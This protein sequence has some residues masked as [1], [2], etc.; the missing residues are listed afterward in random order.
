MFASKTKTLIGKI[1][2]HRIAKTSCAIVRHSID[3]RFDD[4]LNENPGIKTHDGLI[5]NKCPIVNTS[6]LQDIYQYL[7]QFDVI[8]IS[9]GQFYPDLIEYTENVLLFDP[10]DKAIM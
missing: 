7:I 2:R 4:N 3:T 1:D 5:Y 6:K 8:G 10:D 9:E